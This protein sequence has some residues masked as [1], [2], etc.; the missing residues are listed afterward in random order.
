MINQLIVQVLCFVKEKKNTLLTHI[1]ENAYSP[2]LKKNPV[3]SFSNYNNKTVTLLLGR[4]MSSFR[5]MG[6]RDK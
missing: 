4:E 5:A 1:P 2:L 6:L 3:L